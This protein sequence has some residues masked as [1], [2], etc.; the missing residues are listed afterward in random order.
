MRIK[1]QFQNN[2]WDG[3][4]L[5]NR[6][7]SHLIKL[8]QITSQLC[9]EG[10]PLDTFT[11][12]YRKIPY[13]NWNPP[14]RDLLQASCKN[15]N[16]DQVEIDNF[17]LVDSLNELHKPWI[18]GIFWIPSEDCH[19]FFCVQGGVDCPLHKLFCVSCPLLWPTGTNPG[20]N[21]GV[22]KPSEA[23]AWTKFAVNVEKTYKIDEQ[24]SSHIVTSVDTGKFLCLAWSLLTFP[25]VS[26]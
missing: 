7:S 9:H 16:D 21:T 12:D 25:Y 22:T 24:R 2:F 11:S 1:D 26:D 6:A 5:D 8:N 4:P 14:V 13:F 18:A 23:L 15:D 17:A 20:T 10:Q 19:Y 3:M